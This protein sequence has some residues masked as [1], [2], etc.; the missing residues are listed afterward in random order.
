MNLLNLLLK[1]QSF[2]IKLISITI[3]VDLLIKKRGDSSIGDF[4]YLPGIFI[5]TIKISRANRM[6]LAFLSFLL[7][8]I[9]GKYPDRGI[10]INKKGV[11][12]KIRTDILKDEI[13]EAIENIINFNKNEPPTFL[14]AHCMQ[15][16]FKNICRERAIQEDNLSLIDRITAKQIKKLEKKGIFTVRQLSYIYKPRRKNKRNKNS[17]LLYKPELQALAIRTQKTFVKELPFLERKDVEI[18]I[19]VESIPE[20]N[21]FYLFGILIVDQEKQQYLSFWSDTKQEEKESCE[22][23]VKILMAYK[24]API[25]H[26]GSYESV[27]F[28]KL[29]KKYN[30]LIQDL[31]K[32]FININQFIFGKIYFPA[33]SNRLKELATI[34]GFKWTSKESSGLQSIIW[35]RHWEQG[36]KH[37]KDVI[38]NYNKEDCIALKILTNEL[39]RIQYEAAIS[40]DIDFVHNSK[41][42]STDIGQNLH[43]QFTIALELAHHE[44]AKKK[45]KVDFKKNGKD[46]QKGSDE[47]INLLQKASDLSDDQALFEL[48]TY[49]LNGF[50]VELDLDRGIKMIEKSESLGNTKSSLFLGKINLFGYYG[51]EI[52]STKAEKFLLKSSESNN[53]EASEL[54]GIYY[55]KKNK[56]N[57]E[58]AFKYVN[59]SAQNG[60]PKS[61]YYLGYLYKNGIFVEEDFQ[62]AAYWF[63]KS[64]K[65]GD[66]Q[67]LYSLGYLFFKGLG[68]PQDYQKAAHFF[69]LSAE[70]NN[71][72]GLMM[73][74]LCYRE[75]LGLPQ[76]QDAAFYFLNRSKKIYDGFQVNSI[77]NNEIENHMRVSSKPYSDKD[78]DVRS[79][80][81]KYYSE[82]TYKKIERKAS[83]VNLN[84]NWKGKAFIYDWGGIK[85]LEE[86]NVILSLKDNNNNVS[87]LLKINDSIETLNAMDGNHRKSNF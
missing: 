28:D 24:D 27:V 62:K 22:K 20:E 6:A 67:A 43:N 9:Q 85:I 1:K 79:D 15:C 25:Y 44:Y 16:A 45:I 82:K 35:R 65:S 36:D 47:L 69:N 52:D 71:P 5:G 18:F 49:Y 37:N 51:F 42:I 34:L 68:V 23:A 64:S 31:K 57:Y 13:T 41:N 70:K 14:N 60:L 30:I 48:G 54:L 87:G 78:I 80:I 33:Y 12:T 84:G 56:P 4:Y 63:T 53:L 61:E 73:L 83:R 86:S 76:S 50:L 29:S 10:A 72:M 46:D 75:G 77:L 2:D 39:T 59:L 7:E 11:L 21:F 81:A 58:L 3:Y 40:D 19:D 26:Y 74:G 55:L 8:K 38:L 66:S 17:S 32:R